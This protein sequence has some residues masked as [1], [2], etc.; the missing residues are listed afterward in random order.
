[1]TSVG[2]PMQ[3]ATFLILTAL[4]DRELHGYGIITEVKALSSGRVALGPGT[5][6]GAL[7]RLTEQG[8]IRPTTTEVVDGRLRRYYGISGIGL[9]A[10]RQ[11]AHQRADT[12]RAAAER[13]G[14]GVRRALA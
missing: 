8:L 2:K 7:D 11:E 9:S 14:P 10:V 6:Y 3:D 4:A 1:V 5:L 13:L 12:L